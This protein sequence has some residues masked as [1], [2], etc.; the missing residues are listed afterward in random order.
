MDSK[1][2]TKGERKDVPWQV[3]RRS[4]HRTDPVHARVTP[5]PPEDQQRRYDEDSGEDSDFEASFGD[6]G[7]ATLAGHA[8]VDVEGLVVVVGEELR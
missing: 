1:G 3:Q 5:S 2:A 7:T 4:H 8:R 6:E